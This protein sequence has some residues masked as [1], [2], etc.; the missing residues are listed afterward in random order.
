MKPVAYIITNFIEKTVEQKNLSLYVTADGKYLA[1][2]KDYNTVLKFDLMF[3]DS[4]F[5]GQVL[6]RGNDG[7]EIQYSVNIPW[8]NGSALRA[9]MEQV[10]AL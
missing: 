3:S 1:M 2:D 7:L 10:K 4:D 6:A 8:T 9:F 5:S